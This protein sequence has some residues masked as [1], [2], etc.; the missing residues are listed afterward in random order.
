MK[1]FKDNLTWQTLNA[2]CFQILQSRSFI[3]CIIQTASWILS[4]SL[5]P[6]SSPGSSGLALSSVTSSCWSSLITRTLCS[7]WFGP[8]ASSTSTAS[9]RTRNRTQRSQS[10]AQPFSV[11]DIFVPQQLWHHFMVHPLTHDHV[12]C[13]PGIRMKFGFG[14]SADD[15]SAH[16]SLWTKGHNLFRDQRQLHS[17][18]L[19]YILWGD[20]V[21]LWIFLW[22]KEVWVVCA[23]I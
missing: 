1:D 21:L 2:P 19:Y 18:H 15:T 4:T 20:S 5:S 9:A 7:C 13:S 3:C 8:G 6:P 10:R 22:D 12:S 11:C 14:V 16:E 17:L 23:V